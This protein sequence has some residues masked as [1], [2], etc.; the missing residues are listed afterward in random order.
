MSYEFETG[1]LHRSLNEEIDSF[2]FFHVLVFLRRPYGDRL[3]GA[4]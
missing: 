1:S 2:S 4:P 3:A